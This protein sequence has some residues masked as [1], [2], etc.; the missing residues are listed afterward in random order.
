MRTAKDVDDI[1]EAVERRCRGSAT[2]SRSWST[3]TISAST[4]LVDAYADMVRYMEDAYYT[5]VSR[6]TT[7]AFL[8]VKLGDALER[9]GVKP[10]L[11][12][13]GKGEGGG[14]PRGRSTRIR[15]SWRFRGVIVAA[16][17]GHR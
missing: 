10:H 12:E 13:T 14:P 2:G 9:A 16:F 3:T 1:K 11:F 4:E 5:E 15:P 7:S 6:Y 17:R 8:R